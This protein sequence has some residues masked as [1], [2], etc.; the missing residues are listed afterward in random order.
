MAGRH[1][2]RG[3]PLRRAHARTWWRRR[4]GRWWCATPAAAASRSCWCTAG[5]P[6][7]SPTGCRCSSPSPR[8]A[9]ARSPSTCPATA[10]ARSSAGSRSTAAPLP[11]PT[12]WSGP[13]RERGRA[14]GG[15]RRLLD[16]R[17]HLPDRRR[18]H[19]E[20]GGRAGAR[21]PPPPTSSRAGAVEGVMGG[22]SRAAGIAEAAGATLNFV[23]RFRR[24]AALGRPGPGPRRPPGVDGAGHL[25]AGPARSGRR[26]G[27]VRLPVVGRRPRRGGRVGRDPRRPGRPGRRPTGA[28]PSC[29]GPGSVELS[30]GHVACLRPGF[31]LATT[32]A[33]TRVVAERLRR[34]PA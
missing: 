8:P 34:F 29:C 9:T 14:A 19:P 5:S 13:A 26:A 24:G 7:G 31:G 25:E 2:H 6:T 12:S 1:R 20:P 18:D 22:F 17:A 32:E 16:G 23:S 3:R 15:A 4:S 21:S 27:P 11:S 28:G 10:A 33:V 30:W